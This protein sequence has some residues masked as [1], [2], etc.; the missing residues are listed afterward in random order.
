MKSA[1]KTPRLLI[2]GKW[3]DAKRTKP[4][5]N[6]YSGEEIAQIPL[7]DSQTVDEAIKIAHEAFAIT[8]TETPHAR[9]DLLQRVARRIEERR[10]DF[11]ETMIAEAG[12]PYTFADAEVTRAIITFREASEEARRQHGEL[13]NIDAYSPGSGHF[14]LTRRFPLGVISAITPFNFPLNLVAHKVAPG[15][16]AGNTLVVKPSLKT[17]LTALLL[18]EMLV[19][20]GMPAGQV[21]FIT[22]NDEESG[23]LVTDPR[24]RMV[25]FTGSSAVGWRLKEQCGK[26]KITL[27]LGGNAGVIVHDDADLE[28]A[29]PKIAVGAFSYAGQSCISVQRV[30]VQESIYDDFKRQFVAHVREHVQTGDPRDKKTVVG[31]LI[32]S[33]ALDRIAGW[34][35]SAR[36]SG[37][38]ILC[39]GNVKGRCLDATIVERPDRNLDIFVK[40]A[41]APIV[42]LHSYN[43]FEDALKVINDSHFGLQAGVFTSDIGRAMRAFEQL[44]VGGVLVNN[45]PTF[46]A[47][48]MPYGGVKDSGFGR[49][50]IRYA[51]EEMTEI[52]SLIFNKT[53]E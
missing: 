24:I 22:C 25:S 48:N 29:I 40:E 38:K 15:V 32:D 17:P 44:D 45:V 16:A 52:K 51:M 8:R 33:G 23:A 31:P 39:G 36:K 9:G 13:L 5:M 1:A 12:K 46:R 53:W 6:P 34:L 30:L 50:G 2:G 28:S 3:C 27:E 10:A 7:G 41:F 18:A 21:N 49:E 37:A 35:E 26:K 11:V 19:E 47:D 42:T 14:G 4:V 20:C 43:N